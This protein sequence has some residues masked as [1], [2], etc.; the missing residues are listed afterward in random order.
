MCSEPLKPIPIPP[1]PRTSRVHGLRY[2]HREKAGEGEVEE[3]SILEGAAD[4]EGRVTSS[5]QPSISSTRPS[6]D[7]N[8]YRIVD[9]VWHYSSVD[10]GRNCKLSR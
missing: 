2:L 3:Q 5:E 6:L 10:W 1:S 7:L 4:L 9:D 8:H